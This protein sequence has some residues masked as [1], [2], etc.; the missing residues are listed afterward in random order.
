MQ[1]NRTRHDTLINFTSGGIAASFTHLIVVP[2]DVVKTK[3]QLDSR[4]TSSTSAFRLIESDIGFKRTVTLGLVPT[5]L[6]YYL[7][8]ICK[9]GLYEIF[10]ENVFSDIHNN[11]AKSLVSATCAEAVGDVLLAP[12]EAVRIFQ[13]ADHRSSYKTRRAFL[14]IYKSE[15]LKGF[16]KGLFPLLLKQIPYTASKFV[17]YEY[18][19]DSLLKH[20]YFKDGDS[21]KLRIVTSA[22]LG[23]IVSAIVS[24]PADT[25][26]SCI[27]SNKNCGFLEGVKKMSERGMWSGLRPRLLMVGGLAS[28]QLIT[29]ETVRSLLKTHTT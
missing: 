15:G 8:G 27:N 7:Q 14:A 2:L 1:I 9:Y 21:E 29:F 13:V 11:C 22:I 28:L 12:F 10:K 20:N 17:M 23:G 4:V 18:A 5:G 25:L 19:Q 26:L 6:G 24:H 3:I 16:Y